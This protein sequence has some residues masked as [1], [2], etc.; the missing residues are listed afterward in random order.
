MNNSFPR[1][2][3]SASGCRGMTLVEVVT[4]IFI[5]SVSVT[6][7]FRFIGSGDMLRGRGYRVSVA[8]RVA[9]NETERLRVIAARREPI[10]DTSYVDHSDGLELEVVRSVVRENDFQLRAIDSLGTETVHVAVVADDGRDTLV[11][12]RFAQ[13]YD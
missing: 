5:L 4:A 10:Q 2:R 6:F 9:Q 13:G 1:Q 12:F 7:L 11:T 3:L 8:T